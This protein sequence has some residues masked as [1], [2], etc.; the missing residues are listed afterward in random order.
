MTWFPAGTVGVGTVAAAFA[1][2]DIADLELWLDADDA[3]TITD[4]AGEVSQWDDK[5]VE[6]NDVV[7]A[8]AANQG[9]T[10]T[11]NGNASIF[12]DGTGE[13]IRDSSPTI[14]SPPGTLAVV[15]TP[16]SVAAGL[17]AVV[18]LR[19][20]VEGVFRIRRHGDELE[21]E[22]GQSP[23]QTTMTIADVLAVDETRWAIAR[24]RNSGDGTSDLLTDEDDSASASVAASIA[25]I[26]DINIAANANGSDDWTGH[27]HEV[28]YYNRFLTDQER[29]DLG[30]Y[31]S[32]K[33]T[34]TAAPADIVIEEV[35]AFDNDIAAIEDL[36]TVDTTADTAAFDIDIP[37]SLGDDVAIVLVVSV[38]ISFS[39]ALA[40]VSSATLGADSWNVEATDLSTTLGT[41]GTERSISLL[42]IGL[43]DAPTSG[44]RICTLTFDADILDS[45]NSGF[46]NT[47]IQAFAYI[48]SGANQT[49]LD[50]TGFAEHTFL[51]NGFGDTGPSITPTNN[52]SLVISGI[53]CPSDC[54][55]TATGVTYTKRGDAVRPEFLQ[56]ADFIQTT[57]AAVATDW[58]P[59]EGGST[60]G[61]TCTL[62]IARA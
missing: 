59:N 62:S 44:T 9:N 38:A 21:A 11:I 34:V 53:V 2:T 46:Q 23:S 58:T 5:S 27:I 13:R 14:N 15:F 32:D 31:L 42:H 1:P 49:G 16:T 17:G 48:L 12:F 8:T 37:A 41:S 33:W 36:I 39:D 10:D 50:Q 6:G 43:G 29:T 61:Q 20:G 4:T 57:A 55:P 52:D 56:C 54:D 24:F 22:E 60:D 40:V 3:G 7:Q 35:Q 18:R 30:T 19:N 26:D 45:D 47:T 25:D 51:T 28:I